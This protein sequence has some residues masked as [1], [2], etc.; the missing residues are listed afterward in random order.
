LVTLSVL[1][2]ALAVLPVLFAEVGKFARQAKVAKL[3]RAVLVQQDI[4]RLQI[5]VDNAIE[6]E[7]VEALSKI[8]SELLQG[9]LGQLFVLLDQLQQITACAVLEN[10]P[11]VVPRL[12]PVVKLE[13]VAIF[14]IM[15][16]SHLV[17]DF[18]TAE[19]LDR[20]YCHILDSLLLSSLVDNGVFA[21]AD[22]L[23]DVKVVHI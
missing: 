4:A 7:V 13:D 10:D 6:V 12:V 2:V 1:I 18:A 19:F 20:F 9:G 16:D 22:L 11:Q 5:A 15:E 8:A 3:E 21:A 23:V 17:E 14:Q